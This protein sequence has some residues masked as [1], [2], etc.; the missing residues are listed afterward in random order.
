MRNLLI[1]IITAVFVFTGRPAVA[2]DKYIVAETEMDAAEESLIFELNAM[3]GNRYYYDEDENMED[4]EEYEY[5]NED[6]DAMD[7]D[8]DE[9][10]D[11]T[12]TK[13]KVAE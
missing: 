2:D 4:E 5:Y 9:D 3:D 11:E 10:D 7:D 1:V 12:D 8:E 6:D 13:Y